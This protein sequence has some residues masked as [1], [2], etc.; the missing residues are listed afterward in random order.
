VSGDGN[1]GRLEGR[2]GKG[3]M[4]TLGSPGG[5]VFC[6]RRHRRWAR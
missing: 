1:S 4:G 3:S 2:E 5:R 6:R